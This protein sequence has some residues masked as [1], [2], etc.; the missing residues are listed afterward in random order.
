MSE[1][2]E[3]MKVAE[4]AAYFRVPKSTVYQLA[5]AGHLRGTKIG[6]HWRFSRTVVRDYLAK[7]ERHASG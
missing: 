1:P 6:K 5:R 2:D 4:V 3:V 7:A